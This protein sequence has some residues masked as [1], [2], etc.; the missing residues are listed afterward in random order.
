MKNLYFIINALAL[1][2]PSIITAQQKSSNYLSFKDSKA[3]HDFYQLDSF[4]KKIPVPIV[5]GHRGTIENNFPESSIAGFEY[6]LQQMPAVF[7]IDPRLTKD[8]VIVVFHDA[9]LERTTNGTGRLIDYTWRELQRLRLKN[10]KGEL[11]DYKIHTLSEIL[12]WARGKTALVLDKKNVPLQ[13]IA[14]IIRKHNANSYVMN[15]VRSTE[16]ALFY[17]KDNP[18]RMFS[19]SIRKPEVFYSYMEAGIPTTQMFAC[20]GTELHAETE[21]LCELLRDHGIRCLLATASSYDKLKTSALRAEAY[22]KVI[23]A[24]V[25][26]IESNY[27][28]EVGEVLL[29]KQ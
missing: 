12:E 16:D 23:K 6:V 7:E 26:I 4:N 8:S 19:V 22:Q 14:D 18:E 28:V 15:M 24:G 2:I 21:A 13:M 27:P 17:F 20:I 5:Q 11:T 25:S 9:T 10:G 1:L 29:K 3:L